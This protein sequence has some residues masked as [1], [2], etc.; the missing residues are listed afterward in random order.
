MRFKIAFLLIV[1]GTSSFAQNDFR[2]GVNLDDDG[3]FVNIVQHTNRYSKAT[4]YD[5]LGWPTSDFDLV[6]MDARPATEWSGT[7]DDPEV[8]RQDVSGR[9]ACGFKG[10]ADVNVSGTSVAIENKSYDAPSNTTTFDLVLGGFP[11]AN[12][13]L[14]FLSLTNTRRTS[15]SANK[16]GITELKVHRPG[17]PLNSNKIFTDA[18]INLCKAASFSCYRYY[19]LQ[20][21]WNGEPTFPATTKWS[22]RKTPRDAAQVDQNSTNGKKDGWCWEYIKELANILNQDIWVNIHQSCDS[23]YVAELAKYLKSNLNSGIRIYVENSNEVWS[24]SQ[25]T[26]GPYNQAMAQA[27]GISFD[28]S[29]ARRSVELSNWFAGVFGAEET[30]NRIRVILAGQLGYHGRSDNHL[31]YI[32]QAFGSPNKFIYAISTSTYFGSTRASSTDPTDINTGMMEAIKTQIEDSTQATYRLR[33]VNKA[34]AWKLPGGCT[35]YEGGPHLPAGGG[36]ANLNNQILAHR[37]KEMGDVLKYNYLEGWKHLGGGLA[38]H[39]T[40]SSAYNRYGCWG[41]TDDYKNPNRNYKMAAIRDLI[42]QT[43][44]VTPYEAKGFSV[45]P[46]PA[47]DELFVLREQKPPL[48]ETKIQVHN[49]LGEVLECKVTDQNGLLAVDVSG[50][51]PGIYFLVVD[52]IT[53]RFIKEQP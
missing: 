33:Y 10:M 24:P 52:S 1:F 28:Q 13:G 37:T 43:S 26:H 46:N 48:D 11:N 34:K 44:G 25:A 27:R 17:Y 38:M 45:Y 50:L 5:S 40:L 4:G 21:I 15:A 16:T 6:L 9:Y 14:V 23:A 39:F 30:N 36:T 51:S 35:S 42:D 3:A 12:H 22:N 18:Y 47:G 2:L 53:H 41:L 19:N 20:N 49:L 8:F 31:N 7:I 29:Y 32:Q